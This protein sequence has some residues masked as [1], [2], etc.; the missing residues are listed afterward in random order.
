MAFPPPPSKL[1]CGGRQAALVDQLDPPFH[2]GVEIVVRGKIL[3]DDIVHRGGDHARLH[4]FPDFLQRHA[5]EFVEIL[6][7]VVL[8]GDLEL[9]GIR[10]FFAGSS[11]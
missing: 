9:L 1:L 5:H 11:V 2:V 4:V 3:L 6:V 10:D 7:V 8:D